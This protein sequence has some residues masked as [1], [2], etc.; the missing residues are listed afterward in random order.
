LR[1][2]KLTSTAD[3]LFEGISKAVSEH[4]SH[5]WPDKYVNGYQTDEEFC[6]RVWLSR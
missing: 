1:A 6:E 5:S 3:K 2:N 4:I